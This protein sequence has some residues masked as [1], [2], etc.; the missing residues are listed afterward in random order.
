MPTFVPTIEI[1]I[2]SAYVG[3]T[4]LKS[5]MYKKKKKNYGKKYIRGKR[6]HSLI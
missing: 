4:S 5:I 2:C 3:H 6:V 1:Y